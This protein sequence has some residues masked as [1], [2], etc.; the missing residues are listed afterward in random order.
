MNQ[1]E[2]WQLGH[3]PCSSA[4]LATSWQGC[5]WKTQTSAR[6][7]HLPAMQSGNQAFAWPMILPDVLSLTSSASQLLIQENELVRVEGLLGMGCL[8]K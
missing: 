4:T 3:E 5:P 8:D 2:L 7:A 1:S 6:H